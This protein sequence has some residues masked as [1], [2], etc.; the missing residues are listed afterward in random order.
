MDPTFEILMPRDEGMNC[1]FRLA[2]WIERKCNYSQTQ[3]R[4]IMR[5]VVMGNGYIV[6]GSDRHCWMTCSPFVSTDALYNGPSSSCS[7]QQL[8]VDSM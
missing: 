2:Y 7:L 1:I 4:G 3:V 8:P 6:S 5:S